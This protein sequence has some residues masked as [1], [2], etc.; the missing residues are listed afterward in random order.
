MLAYRRTTTLAVRALARNCQGGVIV[1][2]KPVGQARAEIG[3]PIGS[4]CVFSSLPE[5]IVVGMPGV[6]CVPTNWNC[7]L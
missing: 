7:C 1:G 2:S 6:L 4:R 5:H 3:V